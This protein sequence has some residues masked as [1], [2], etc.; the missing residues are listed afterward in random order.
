MEYDFVM[1]IFSWNTVPHKHSHNILWYANYILNKLF[2]YIHF[3]LKGKWIVSKENNYDA[4]VFQ[5]IF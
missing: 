1:F 5:Q 4:Y 2:V 3:H